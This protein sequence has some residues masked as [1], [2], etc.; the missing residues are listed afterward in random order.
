MPK[1]STKITSSRK[2]KGISLKQDLKS[3]IDDSM[4]NDVVITCNDGVDISASRIILATRC[5]ILNTLLFEGVH[6]TRSEKVRLS[7]IS[8]AQFTVVLE[9]IYTEEAPSLSFSNVIDVSKAAEFFMLP[10]LQE[11]VAEYVKANLFD[12]ITA[13]LIFS[14]AIEGL[15]AS[16]AD[17]LIN[18]ARQYLLKSPLVDEQFIALSKRALE[19][20]LSNTIAIKNCRTSP[21]DLFKCVVHWACVYSESGIGEQDCNK[22]MAYFNDAHKRYGEEFHPTKYGVSDDL[23]KKVGKTLAPFIEK[24]RFQDMCPYH[25]A[26]VADA[27]NIVPSDL[28]YAVFRNRLRNA[29]EA[30]VCE[31]LSSPSLGKERKPEKKKKTEPSNKQ[32]I[33]EVKL[34]GPKRRMPVQ[35]FVLR[36]TKFE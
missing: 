14:E 11:L 25:L 28:L 6:K 16:A 15:E 30:C 12:H 1:V 18:V 29:A 21:F 2:L 23:M 32:E 19:M 31:P 33:G 17:T 7:E 20:M 22:L 26:A 5:E 35:T 3:T 24:I 4:Y 13:G 10:K 8:S 27:A 9:F 34:D 36:S